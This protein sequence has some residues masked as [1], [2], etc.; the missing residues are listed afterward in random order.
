MKRT[1]FIV[2]LLTCSATAW[3]QG[4]G[5]RP[6]PPSIEERL[7]QAKE[8]LTLTEEQLSEWKIIFEK[9]DDQIQEARENRDRESGE[10]LRTALNEELLATLNEEQQAKFKEMQKNRSRRGRRR[11]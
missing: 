4:R 8:Q 11:G 10:T 3:A 1:L 6:E 9:Y 7:D 5:Q 2:L